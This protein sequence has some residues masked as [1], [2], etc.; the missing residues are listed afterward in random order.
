ME[1]HRTSAALWYSSGHDRL[2]HRFSLKAP[3]PYTSL[4]VA[5]T[6]A[7][8]SHSRRNKIYITAYQFE[9]GKALYPEI[10]LGPLTP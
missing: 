10:F 2:Q 8:S 3:T 4:K 6:M 5:T 1:R 9:S 7:I